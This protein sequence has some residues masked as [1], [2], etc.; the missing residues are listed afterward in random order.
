[1]ILGRY[2]PEELNDVFSFL[3]ATEMEELL[4]YL[5][6]REWQPGEILMQRGDPGAWLG[7]LIEGKLA[8]KMEA[9][10][11]EKFILVAVLERGSLVGEVAVVE[12]IERNATVVAIN[13]S[14]LLVLSKENLEMMLKQ[15]PVLGL[16]LFR[17]IIHV[18]SHRLSK[19][20]D[21][22]ARLL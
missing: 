16:K 17:W 4:T 14:H 6:F 8:V 2:R 13:E 7:F 20:S 22:L 15:T 5:E 3:S 9:I 18:L 1:M 10:F 19:A 11:P 21:R 12:G